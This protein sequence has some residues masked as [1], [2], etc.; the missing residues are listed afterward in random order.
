MDNYFIIVWCLI[1]ILY[2]N[3]KFDQLDIRP[4][5]FIVG[6]RPYLFSMIL[7]PFIILMWFFLL[8]NKTFQDQYDLYMKMRKNDK[9]EV[10]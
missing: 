5:N 3:I 2:T 8:R 6:L 4:D 10:K 1:G 7:G 9:K